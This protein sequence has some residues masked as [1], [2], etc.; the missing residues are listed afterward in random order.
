M[1]KRAQEKGYPF[2]YLFDE[3]Q[4]IAKAY[5]ATRTPEVYLLDPSFTVVYSGRI[6]DNTE[7]KDVKER[8]LTKAIDHLLAGNAGAI[9]PKTTKAFGCTIKW[10]D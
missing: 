6:D 4:A 7:A 2:P 8:D 5:G 1:Q 10:K 9:D 3:T